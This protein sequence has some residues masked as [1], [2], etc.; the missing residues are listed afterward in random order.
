MYSQNHFIYSNLLIL[1]VT[2]KNLYVTDYTTI[3]FLFPPRKKP[4]EFLKLHLIYVYIQ[5]QLYSFIAAYII[6]LVCQKRIDTYI[7]I[8]FL[9]SY[10][11]IIT[12]LQLPPHS[13]LP[14][15]HKPLI[16][17]FLFHQFPM[18]SLL[19][20]PSFIHN[21]NLVRISYRLKPMCNH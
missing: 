18:G 7:S 1:A 2:S 16:Y 20:N 12:P 6:Y 14:G 10:F 21:Q 4:D 8:L 15:I 17:S 9:S 11:T 13:Q 19:D 5:C 3:H